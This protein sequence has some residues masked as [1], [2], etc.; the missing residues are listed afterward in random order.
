MRGGDAAEHALRADE[1]RGN[2]S[3]ADDPQGEG[4]PRATANPRL[5][6][7]IRAHL[8]EFG[9]VAP[10]GVHNVG[11]LLEAG[12]RAELPACA[13]AP[14]R[15]LADQFFQTQEKIDQ[16][17]RDIRREA[18]ANDVAKRLRAIP[19]IGPITATALTATLPNVSGFRTSRDLSAWLGARSVSRT[20]RVPTRAA[21]APFERGQGTARAYFQDGKPLSAPLALSRCDG[22][23]HG[24]PAG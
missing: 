4:V 11:G 23:D 20:D 15:L 18:D 16:L 5:T 19:G 10:K 12:E 8:G 9:I 7:A 17:T 2:P 6:N 14:L 13:R 1:K 21:E 3:A 22:G 24:P